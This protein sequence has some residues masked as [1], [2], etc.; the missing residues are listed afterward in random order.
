MIKSWITALS[1]MQRGRSKD[2]RPLSGRASAI[3]AR[4]NEA[5]AIRYHATDVVTY[6]KDG[7]IVLNSGGY[8]TMTTKDRMNCYSP[9]SVYQES[10][11]WYVGPPYR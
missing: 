4:D 10:G 5:V 9:A 6:H 3:E 1:Y 8:R 11:L 2:Y 7:R